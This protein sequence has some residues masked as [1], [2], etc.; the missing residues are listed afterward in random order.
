MRVGD[1]VK[2]ARIVASMGG[3]A[4]LERF[5]ELWGD[6]AFVVIKTAQAWGVLRR[7]RRKKGGGARTVLVLGARGVLLLDAAKDRCLLDARLDGGR[8]RVST[9][10]G[11]LDAE[12]SAG[13]L[14]SLAYNLSGACGEDPRA[15]YDKLRRA[16]GRAVKISRGLERWLLHSGGSDLINIGWPGPEPSVHS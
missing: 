9:P 7:A 2:A 1:V 3:E 13:F 5:Y 15:L 6:Y 10:F 12:P 4:P 11:V 16:V 8:L 14:L